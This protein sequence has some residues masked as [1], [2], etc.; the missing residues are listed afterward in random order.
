MSRCR[1]SFRLNSF[2]LALLALATA[3]PVSAQAAV[4]INELDSD[5]VST[6]SA[7]FV[8]LYNDAAV[9]MSLDGHVLVLF[10]GSNDLSY[11]AFDLDG[12]TVAAEDYFVLGS[13][14]VPNVDLL[15]PGATNQLQNGAD[16]VALYQGDASDFPNGTLITTANLVDAVA[17]DTSDAD[18]VG[19]LMLLDAGQ[20]QV[21][22]N[23]GGD[24]T[25]HSIQRR[26]DGA[27][28]ARNTSAFV[29]DLPTPGASNAGAPPPMVESR[30]IH[31]IQG[32][33][34]RSPLE[35][36]AVQTR[37]IVSSIFELSAGNKGF[38]LQDPDGDGND[39]TSEG[40]LV[41]V[42]GAAMPAIQV[43][44]EVS[45]VGQV[46]EF[47]PG[48]NGTLNLSITEITGPQVTL[49]SD[50]IFVNPLAPTVIGAAGRLAPNVIVDDDTIGVLGV[51][52]PTRMAYDRVVPIVD[53][54][55]RL[56]ESA[57]AL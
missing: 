21:N 33:Q 26:P 23:G 55:A 27:G 12:F 25:G 44:D 28:G 19:L 17:Y 50:T 56:L 24:G 42:G 41:F 51:I 7:E 31:E 45:V 36:Q 35:G 49:E 10:N 11:A 3:T 32:E 6:D 22:E 39:A 40:I 37:G 29:T 1:P 46:T 47:R 16:A 14:A 30:R 48:G 57:R 2:R 38:Y 4:L 15:F 34:H 9:P 18:D 20:S 52:G 53:V 43:G 8:E 54:T 5:Q 13:G